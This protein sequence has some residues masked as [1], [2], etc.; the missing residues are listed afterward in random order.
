MKTHPFFPVFVC[1]T[2]LV[3]VVLAACGPSTSTSGTGPVDASGSD[4]ALTDGPLADGST[5]SP[6]AG[7][8]NDGATPA[9]SAA[10]PDADPGPLLAITG[11]VG[12]DTLVA[13]D[14]YAHVMPGTD[15]GVKTRVMLNFGDRPNLCGAGIIRQDEIF[16][17]IDLQLVTDGPQPGTFPIFQF[18]QTAL[19]FADAPFIHLDATTCKP[20]VDR[21][22]Q[23]GTVT[24][25][26][27]TATAIVGSFDITYKDGAVKG[28]FNAPLSCPTLPT[29]HCAP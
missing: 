23:S 26:A 22:A 9:D 14:G 6:D 8:S 2:P 25:S 4:V 11:S 27:V 13:V 12:G 3:A 10:A 17:G 29:N 7:P 24:I 28:T 15:P 21:G 18:P 19:P 1:A 5:P 20:L 16:F